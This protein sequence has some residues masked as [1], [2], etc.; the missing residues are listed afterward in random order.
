MLNVETYTTATIKSSLIYFMTGHTV[1]TFIYSGGM[2]QNLKN[3]RKDRDFR[4][5]V[6]CSG[7]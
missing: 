3:V 5:E 1:F 2:L 7:Q 4:K 6:K